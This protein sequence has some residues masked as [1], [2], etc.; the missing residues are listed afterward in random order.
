MNRQIYA[1]VFLPDEVRAKLV[2]RAALLDITPDE[3]ARRIVVAAIEPEGG[4]VSDLP[5]KPAS[6]AP[7][8]GAGGI[9]AFVFS[10]RESRPSATLAGG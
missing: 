5:I 3:L 7:G 1:T 6:D 9:V 10:N 2:S 4:P 8:R